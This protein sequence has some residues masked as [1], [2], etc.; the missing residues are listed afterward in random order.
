MIHDFYGVQGV[1]A[2][3]VEDLLTAG[4]AGSGD[5]GRDVVRY[6]GQC[7]ADGGEEQHLAYGQRGL[8]VLF[9]IAE[10]A[11]H[12]ATGGWNDVKVAAGQQ[13]QH[14]GGLVDADE[15]LLVTVAV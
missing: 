13:T 3:A 7:L 12:A 5:V 11:C 10:G 15:R 6:G 9:F 1:V 14:G 4:G 8:V 2:G